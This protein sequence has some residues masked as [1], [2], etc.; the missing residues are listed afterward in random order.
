MSTPLPSSSHH[1]GVSAGDPVIVLDHVSKHFTKFVAVHEAHFNIARGE[2]FS[3]LG[4]S[5]CGKTTTLRMIAGFEQPTSGRILLEGQDVSTTPP[6]KRNVNTVF[7]HYALFPHMSVRDNVAFGPRCKKLE[8]K[9]VDR[10]VDELLKVVR[11]DTFASRKPGQ[12]SGGQ[13]QRVALARALVNYPS[14][15]LLDEPLGALDLK[16]RQAMQIELKRIQREVG[17]TF[18]YVTHDQ[19]EAMTMSDRIAVMNKGHYEQLGDPES[20]YERP[21]TRFVASFLGISNLLPAKVT[22]SDDGYARASLVDDSTIRVPKAIVDGAVTVDIG[23]RPEKIRLSDPTS[24]AAAGH[25]RLT[26]VVRDASYLGVST[27][28]QVESRAGTLTVYE[29]NVERATRAELWARGDEV[30]MTWSPDHS[31]VVP[32]GGERPSDESSGAGAPATPSH[33]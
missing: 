16:L 33:A 26:G 2:F 13:Q 21:M 14:A 5:G 24:L 18:I 20:L 32:A 15:L 28:Y 8:P 3:M 22:G 7:Q 10:R 11:L 29:Q 19:E 31:F 30:Q 9:E 27:Q 12:L 4:P 1:S 17:I 6:Y 23:V 25:N